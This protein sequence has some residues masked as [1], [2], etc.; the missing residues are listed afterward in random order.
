MTAADVQLHVIAT[1]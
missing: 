1:S